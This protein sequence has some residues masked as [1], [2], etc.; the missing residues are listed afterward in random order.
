MRLTPIGLNAREIEGFY[1][2]FA[3]RTL[4]PLY[5]DAVRPPEFRRE[6]WQSYVETNERFADLTATVASKGATVWVHD[7]Q[8]H[9]V[10]A[11]AAR[12]AARSADRLL[13]A[14][15]AAAAGALHAAPVAPADRRG[16]ARRGPRRLSAARRGAELP[17][18]L[19]PAGRRR[20]D[21]HLDPV[22]G[23][24]G[25]RSG[26]SR[27]RSTS[28]SSTRSRRCRRPRWPPP[29]C[30]RRSARRAGSSSGSTGSTTPRA[31]TSAC[32]PSASCSRAASRTPA[33]RCSSRSRRR[34]ASA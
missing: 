4:W 30:A 31:S 22:R 25:A 23:P 28:P 16:D 12:A 19:P 24:H 18:D 15:P 3:N 14:H 29:P 34:A 2:G 10:P 13:P 17:A 6:W 20:A 1:E 33:R 7:Y 32:R 5:H 27:S 11:H 8:L 9:L 26:R 21:A